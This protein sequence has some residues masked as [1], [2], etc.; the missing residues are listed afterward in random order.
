LLKFNLGMT[1]RS[2]QPQSPTH[3]RHIFSRHGTHPSTL[4]RETIMQ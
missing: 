1:S 2:A 3:P 4:E